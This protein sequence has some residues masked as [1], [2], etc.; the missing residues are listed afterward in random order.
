[1]TIDVEI[2]NLALAH[3]GEDV[4]IADPGETTKAARN[5]RA[6]WDRA[7][8]FLLRRHNWNF[9]M[10]RWELAAL[11]SSSPGY[12][13]DEFHPWGYKFPLPAACLR[14]ANIVEPRIT[15]HAYQLEGRA[16]LTDEAG[17]IHIRGVYDN[18]LVTAWDEAFAELMAIEIA[19]RICLVMGGDKKLKR[20][21]TDQR[22]ASLK[23]AKG[24]DARENPPET[25]PETGWE[26][27]R[28]G[29][30]TAPPP[31]YAG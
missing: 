16:V 29:N 25:L 9:A 5:V 31:G 1:M 11:A 27:A 23:T 26:T 19:Q 6:Q 18:A 8:R 13:A 30:G 15:R 22:N 2:A 7:R 10:R 3:L 21:L 24:L 20:D 17:P 14:F 4:T 12:D 28:Y